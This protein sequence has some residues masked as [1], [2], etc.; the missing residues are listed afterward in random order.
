MINQTQI[1]NI[2]WILIALLVVNTLIGIA[3]I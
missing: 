1:K 2:D 3:V